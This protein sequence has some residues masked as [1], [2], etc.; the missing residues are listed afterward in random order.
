[1]GKQTFNIEID[2][3][4]ISKDDFDKIKNDLVKEI[5]KNSWT[6]DSIGNNSFHVKA[7]FSK[8]AKG[9]ISVGDMIKDGPIAPKFN[10]TLFDPRSQTIEKLVITIED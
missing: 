5:I 7:D 8:H 10:P 6:P 2:R 9:G 1:M 4:N 3:K